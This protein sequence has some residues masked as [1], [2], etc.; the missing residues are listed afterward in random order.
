M[1]MFVFVLDFL[2]EKKLSSTFFQGDE[3]SSVFQRY[4]RFCI[5]LSV[6]L[7][8]SSKQEKKVQNI[9]TFQKFI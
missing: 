9:L 4:F 5:S 7:S 6:Q 1:C 3:T 2:A 8:Q